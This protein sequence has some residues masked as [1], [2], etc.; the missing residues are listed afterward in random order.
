MGN[1]ELVNKE[2][3]MRKNILVMLSASLIFVLALTACGG[4]ADTKPTVKGV[5]F[6]EKL[7]ESY[8]AV[9]PKTQ[10]KPT[11]VIYVSVDIAGRPKT[12]IVNAKFYFGDQ[13]IAEGTL[14]LSSSN[15]GVLFSI[16]ED[17]YAGFWITPTQPW[18]VSK[19]YRMELY[20]D[21]VKVGSYP[22][23]VI[24]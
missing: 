3:R 1:M 22:Y 13:F 15:S 10:F 19:D 7:N 9:N 18:P 20:L 14:D 12:G 24:E 2:K 6:A 5:S 21:S 23:E 11:D 16:G 4:A 8:Q 17:T